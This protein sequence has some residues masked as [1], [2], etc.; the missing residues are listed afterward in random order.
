M[1]MPAPAPRSRLSCGAPA[2]GDADGSP[3]DTGVIGDFGALTA[4]MGRGGG[5]GD[6]GR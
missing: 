5:K 3:M 1:S 2:T 4:G 6:E